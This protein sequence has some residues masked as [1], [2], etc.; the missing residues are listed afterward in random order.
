MTIGELK[1]HLEG[2]PESHE[3]T[4]AGGL[5]FYRLKGRG[6]NLVNMEFNQSVYKTKEGKWVVDD[7]LEGQ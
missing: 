6:G 7:P 3:I 5:E 2:L 4:F 1:K